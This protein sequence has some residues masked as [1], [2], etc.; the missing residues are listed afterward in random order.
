MHLQSHDSSTP[1]PHTTSSVAQCYT[2]R[3]ECE[4][5]SC[6]PICG[7]MPQVSVQ[8]VLTIGRQ[9]IISP[10]DKLPSDLSTSSHPPAQ[11]RPFYWPFLPSF[12]SF[13]TDSSTG[14]V[15][16]SK[17]LYLETNCITALKILWFCILS[18]FINYSKWFVFK[19]I[20][21]LRKFNISFWTW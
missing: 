11:Y 10:W 13:K 21:E 3:S 1:T 9:V 14:L 19:F 5:I 16:Q 15:F 12:P 20:S 7:I 18:Q 17:V 8:N 6:I 2:H 4:A